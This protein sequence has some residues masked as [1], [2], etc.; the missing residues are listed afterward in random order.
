LPKQL[1]IQANY[2]GQEIGRRVNG[3]SK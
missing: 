1:H 3:L 2:I